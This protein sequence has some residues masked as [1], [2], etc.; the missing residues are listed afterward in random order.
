MKTSQRGLALIA[1]FEGLELKAY[2][3]PG[4]GGE[5]FTIGYGHTGGVK[6]GDTCTKAQALEWLA[7][8][9]VEAEEAIEKYVKVDLSQDQF[10]A[11][12]SFIFNCGAGNF[13]NSTMLSMINRGEFENAAA[14]FVRWNRAAGN[15]MVGLT[16]RRMAESSLFQSELA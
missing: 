16:R 11:L 12:V 3:D 1:E 9:V 15:V 8:D 2:P 13:K 4:T 5:P 6:L 14:Q 7:E 10:D